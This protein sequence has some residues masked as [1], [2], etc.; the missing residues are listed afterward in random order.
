MTKLLRLVWDRSAIQR[1]IAA[2][3]RSNKRLM[4][5]RDAAKRAERA[6]VV[7]MR[8]SARPSP[9]PPIT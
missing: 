8:S 5:E 9:R 6:K 2:W 4:D 7:Q 3:K 1:G